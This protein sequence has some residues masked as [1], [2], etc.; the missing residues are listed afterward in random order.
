M[1]TIRFVVLF[2]CL[3]LPRYTVPNNFQSG[4]IISKPE[5]FQ[6]A[7]GSVP[8]KKGERISAVKELFL[9]MG[10]SE[11]DITI[12]KNNDIQNIVIRKPGEIDE[13][14]IVGAHYDFIGEGSCGAV[15]NWTGIVTIAH[16]YKTLKD[17]KLKKTI[18][19]VGFDQ[20]EKMLAGSKAFT[21]QIKKEE[22]N[23]Y[24]AM[25]NVDSLGLNTPQVLKNVSS[26]KL[27]SACKEIAQKMKIDFQAYEMATALADSD[28]FLARKIPAVTIAA[29]TNDWMEILHHKA[30]QANKINSMSVYLGYRLALALV[31]QINDQECGNYR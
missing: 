6:S 13:K 15:D 30:D 24:C 23:Q 18:L 31:A 3:I 9:K 21:K 22:I 27:E 29:I 20:E 28:S 12:E 1:K 26:P 25:V 2:A 11:A 14:I 7:F 8:C 19:F 17:A 5:E 4:I 10:A 16:I